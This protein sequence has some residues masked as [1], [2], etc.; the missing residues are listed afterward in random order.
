MTAIVASLNFEIIVNKETI[1][2]RREIDDH[3][4]VIETEINDLVVNHITVQ[5]H[6]NR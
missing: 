1:M 6:L 3:D 4:H 2:N 5:N